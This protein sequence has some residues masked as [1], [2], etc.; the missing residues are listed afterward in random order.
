MVDLTERFSSIIAV[1]N[2]NLRWIGLAIDAE[3]GPNRKSAMVIIVGSALYMLYLVHC[4]SVAG[5]LMV[6]GQIIYHIPWMVQYNLK[7]ANMVLQYHLARDFLNWARKTLN[8][9]HPIEILDRRVK[10]T[11]LEGLHLANKITV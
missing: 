8:R 9:N 10:K 2:L 6:A 7:S 11:Q 3:K 4:I 1:V 5:K